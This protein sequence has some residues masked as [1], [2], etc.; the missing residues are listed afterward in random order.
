MWFEFLMTTTERHNSDI[1]GNAAAEIILFDRLFLQIR[2]SLP[3]SGCLLRPRNSYYRP[4]LKIFLSSWRSTCRLTEE[5]GTVI[6]FCF[7]RFWT[8]SVRWTSWLVG[9]NLAPLGCQYHDLEKPELWCA[10]LQAKREDHHRSPLYSS[11]DR[12]VEIGFVKSPLGW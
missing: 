7:L 4:G 3:I 1:K 10:E 9:E 11:A 2:L 5:K 6:H 12:S 8:T